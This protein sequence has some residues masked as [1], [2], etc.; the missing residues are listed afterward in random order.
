MS[1]SWMFFD[2]SVHQTTN[3][4]SYIEHILVVSC[5]LKYTNVLS[6][7]TYTAIFSYILYTIK[8]R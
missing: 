3:M 6:K 2:T 5:H 1:S 7:M 8:I 4:N